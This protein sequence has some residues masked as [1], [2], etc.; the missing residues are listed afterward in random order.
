MKKSLPRVA[1]DRSSPV[2]QYVRVR[3]KSLELPPIK[4]GVVLGREAP[5][6]AEALSRAMAILSKET[7]R[8]VR[9]GDDAIMSDALIRDS[10][11][12]K[13][14]QQKLVSFLR[15]R[16]KPRMTESEIVTLDIQIELMIDAAL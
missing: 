3:L 13:V 6:G 2:E 8:R 12:R 1:I 10:V 5:I 11:L 7:Y 16:V 14:G 9:L 4:D 15:D